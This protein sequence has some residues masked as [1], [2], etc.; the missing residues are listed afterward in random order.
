MRDRDPVLGAYFA[1][2]RGKER[3]AAGKTPGFFRAFPAPDRSDTCDHKLTFLERD[4]AALVRNPP[5]V[6]IRIPAYFGF[7]P[8]CQTGLTLVV[9]GSLNHGQNPERFA[10][11][12][13]SWALQNSYPLK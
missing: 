11:V 12:T 7:N 4:M 3:G 10:H 9:K 13:Q 6:I 1:R 2:K 5:A 8:I